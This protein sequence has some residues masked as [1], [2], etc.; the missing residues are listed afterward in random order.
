MALHK[1]IQNTH[2]DWQ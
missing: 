2:L 1:S